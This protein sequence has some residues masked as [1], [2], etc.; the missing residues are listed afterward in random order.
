MVRK[1]GKWVE[2]QVD[3]DCPVANC[4]CGC[5]KPGQLETTPMSK[6]QR[7]MKL[8]SSKHSKEMVKKKRRD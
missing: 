8:F 3:D 5:F 4:E 7:Q 6:V 1:S 2:S